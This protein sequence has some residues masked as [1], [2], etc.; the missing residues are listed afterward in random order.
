[1]S[2]AISLVLAKI[3]ALLMYKHNKIIQGRVCCLEDFYL[4]KQLIKK[5]CKSCYMCQLLIVSILTIILNLIFNYKLVCVILF[6]D[7]L[8]ILIYNYISLRK[9]YYVFN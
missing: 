5:I 7:L 1:M 6:L 9:L 4:D 3:M 8:L 2:V